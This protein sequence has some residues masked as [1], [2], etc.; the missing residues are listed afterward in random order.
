MRAF[1]GRLHRWANVWTRFKGKR[2]LKVKAGEL[3]NKIAGHK[4]SNLKEL[5]WK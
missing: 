5:E 1:T 4:Y 3:P 2:S